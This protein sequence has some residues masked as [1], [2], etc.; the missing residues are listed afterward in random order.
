MSSTHKDTPAVQFFEDLQHSEARFQAMFKKAAVDMGIMS[1]DHCILD[2]SRV[3]FLRQNPG[4]ITYPENYTQ[5][6][7]EVPWGR[8]QSIHWQTLSPSFHLNPTH[9]H[10][11]P[12]TPLF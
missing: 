9:N 7:S 8:R 3:E 10:V 1:L 2:I 5:P 4:I 12:T 6:S 11:L